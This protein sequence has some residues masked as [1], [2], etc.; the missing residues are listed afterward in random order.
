MFR[1]ALMVARAKE[2]VLSSTAWFDLRAIARLS[3]QNE[4]TIQGQLE[5]WKANEKIFSVCHNNVELFPDYA[6]DRLNNWNPNANLPLVIKSFKS[7]K[8]DWAIAMWL[9]GANGFLGGR[10]PQ[11]L[12]DQDSE[13]LKAAIADELAGITHG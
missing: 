6:F 10:R 1:E 7:L 4:Q 12:L 8:T 9:A 11:D 13:V 5:L 3:K 2:K